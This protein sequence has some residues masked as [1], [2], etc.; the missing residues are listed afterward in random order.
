MHWH[1]ERRFSSPTLA[2][3][4]VFGLP[5]LQQVA[6]SKTAPDTMNVILGHGLQDNP[7]EF[8]FQESYF[9]ASLDPVF[10]AEF[11]RD[12]ELAL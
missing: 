10:T 9:C 8:V 6:P 7:P 1:Q 11:S 3:K 12:Y 5:C 2:L 4:A